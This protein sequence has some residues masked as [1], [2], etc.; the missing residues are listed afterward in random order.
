MNWTNL[1]NLRQLCLDTFSHGARPRRPSAQNRPLCRVCLVLILKIRSE[2]RHRTHVPACSLAVQAKWKNHT[3]NEAQFRNQMRQWDLSA[4]SSNLLPPHHMR[5][6]TRPH[7]TH[8]PN[9]AG[10]IKY[11]K[12][13]ESRFSFA[14]CNRI[15]STHT[16]NFQRMCR[17]TAIFVGILAPFTHLSL[18]KSGHAHDRV[19]TFILLHHMKPNNELHQPS[20]TVMEQSTHNHFLNITA[21]IFSTFPPLFL[22]QYL[23]EDMTR[24]SLAFSVALSRF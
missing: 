5:T 7:L 1:H 12:L 20:F 2:H 24:K 4:F 17:S 18:S 15:P 13:T 3:I 10:H 16:R 23:S 9:I 14:R 21:P 11:R 6:H 8:A 22:W 19:F